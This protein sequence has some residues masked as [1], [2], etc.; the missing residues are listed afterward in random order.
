MKN[1]WTGRYSGRRKISEIV[2]E[3]LVKHQY[4]KYKAWVIATAIEKCYIFD[5][6]GV[7]LYPT[8]VKTVLKRDW[9]S[10]DTGKRSALVN[11][12]RG[13]S[14]FVM[15]DLIEEYMALMHQDHKYLLNASLV[16]RLEVKTTRSNLIAST[17]TYSEG[18]MIMLKI[19]KLTLC[20]LFLV[21]PI[22]ISS[23]R[24]Y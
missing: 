13:L 12:E 2:K 17:P 14:P 23:L 24:D 1:V 4:K 6:A 10:S 15:V 20:T 5:N 3:L 21:F 18:F 22:V 7:P 19:F 16:L 9:T 11:S 8:L